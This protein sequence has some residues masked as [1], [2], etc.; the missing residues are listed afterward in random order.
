MPVSS[1]KILNNPSLQEFA[2]SLIYIMNN[3]GPCTDPLGTP[4]FTGLKSEFVLFTHT[5][6][7]LLE[8]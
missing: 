4:H 2:R 6:C 8:R 3:S 1:T 7:C 5:Y